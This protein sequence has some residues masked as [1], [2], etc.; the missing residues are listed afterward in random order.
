MDRTPKP[1]SDSPSGI[2]PTPI[3]L[4]LIVAIGVA[5][6]ILRVVDLDSIPPGLHFDQAANGLLGLEILSGKTHPV[7]FSS[8]AGREA[9]FMYLIAGVSAV[10]GPG[11]VALRLAGALAGVATVVAVAFLGASLYDRR[12]GVLAAAFLA[13]LYWHLHVSRLGERTILVPLLDTFAL[14]AIWA[15]FRRRSLALAILGGGLTGLQLYTYPSSRFFIAVLL[16]VGLVE[17]MIRAGSSRRFLHLL[18]LP[19]F[20]GGRVSTVAVSPPPKE[21]VRTHLAVL[22]SLVVLAAV[23]TAVPLGL[24]FYHVPSDFFGRSDEVAVWNPL[25]AGPSLLAAVANS[26]ARTLGM[27]VLRGDGDWKYNLANRPVFDPVSA[28][29]FLIGL[30]LAS[31]RW[32]D[33]ADRLCLIWW[34]G[35]LAPSFLSVDAPQFMRPLGAAPAAVLFAARGLDL[36]IRWARKAPAP[37]LRRFAPVLFGWPLVAGGFAAYQYFAVWAPSPAAYFALE[38]DVTAAAGVIRAKSPSYAATYVSSRYGADPTE[39]FLDGDLFSRLHWFDGRSALPLPPPGAGPTLYVLPRSAT[40]DDWYQ[41]LPAADR[42]AEVNGPDGGPA[43]EA[44]VLRPGELQPDPTAPAVSL[45]FGGVARLIGAEVPRA[46]Q[47][48]DPLVATFYWQIEQPPADGVKFFVHLDDSAGQT[49]AQYDEDVYPVSEWRTG[50]T[51]LVRRPLLIPAGAP[52][53]SY[54]LHVGLERANGQGLNATNE[55]GQ[56]VGTFW[57]S[58]PISTIRPQR[59]PSL[60]SLGIA[61]P[62]NVIF[63]DSVRLVGA[64]LPPRSVLDGDSVEIT[65]YWQVIR[66]PAR[67]LETVIQ[68]EGKAGAVVARSARPPTDGV[69]PA[70][71]W[72]PGDVIVDRQQVLIPA[73]T[74]AGPLTLTAG[75]TDAD[76]QPLRATGSPAHIS[77]GSLTVTPRPRSPAAVKIGHPLDV[78]FQNGIRLLGYDV[79]PTSVRPG[80]P[81]QLTLYW[82]TDRPVLAGWTVFTH[83][84]DAKSQVRAQNDSVPVAGARPTTTWAPG[85]TIVDTHTLVVQGDATPGADQLEIGLYDATTGQRLGLAGGGDRV[86][87]DA[88]VEVRPIP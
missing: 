66:A 27:F 21:Q 60:A 41:R 46:G 81:I 82:R 50:Q 28:A 79:D 83:L 40:D 8:Y 80:Q 19:P 23:L 71:D 3:Y 54:V 67:D 45:D 36:V 31:W 13:G 7:F 18:P 72:R 47:A 6:L 10:I 26:T 17:V 25:V 63:G 86:L 24:H 29:L 12:T 87:L 44:F 57:T 34:L 59:P 16:A 58:E 53:G 30:A 74:A 62:L 76:G 1:V 78:A 5:A 15:A 9:L 4:G 65:F 70:H 75:L 56:A 43:V 11:V 35:M 84:L 14:L 20:R 51:L 22:V 38:G 52:V 61:R 42:V 73:G 55:T 68:V 49:W 33:R 64:S 39:S 32:R 2:L 88:S 37:A 69:W 77:I 85:E 48:G